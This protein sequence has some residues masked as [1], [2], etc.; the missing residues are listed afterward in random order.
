MININ[1]I[2][3]KHITIISSLKSR[4]KL[5]VTN[6]HYKYYALLIINKDIVFVNNEA[7]NR[8]KSLII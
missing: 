5:L 1:H 3:N 8:I 4:E 6:E 2:N 7:R